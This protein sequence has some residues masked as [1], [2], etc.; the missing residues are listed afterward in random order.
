MTVKDNLGR[1]FDNFSSL[2][3]DW[4]VSDTN[5]AGFEGDG[6]I[7]TE[8]SQT[9]SGRKMVKCMLMFFLLQVNHRAKEIFGSKMILL[10]PN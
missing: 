3:F 5:L 2:S 1:R 7:K 8:L 9:P 6:N 10:P 4:E